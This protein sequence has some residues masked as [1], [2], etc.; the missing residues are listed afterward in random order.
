MGQGHT[1]GP[2][3][4]R[5]MRHDV[6]ATEQLVALGRGL[7]GEQLDRTVPGTYGSVRTTLAHIVA[8][9]EG[10][11]VRFLGKV[12]HDPPFRCEDDVALEEIATHLAHAK[13]G[14]EQLFARGEL[15]G[16]RLITDTPLRRP[17]QQRFEMNAW[18]PATQFVHHGN[19]HRSQI[20][21][22]RT[23]HGIE[24]PDLQ[25]R[26]LAMQLGARREAR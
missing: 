5:Q 3:M 9:D 8:S 2:V 1:S 6:W 26:P 4:L 17:D 13:D 14:V 10:Y 22:T 18:V 25:V 15:D 16:D 12:L 23:A 21:T 24:P 7:R 11:L 19:D 20:A